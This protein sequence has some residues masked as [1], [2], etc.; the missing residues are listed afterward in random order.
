MTNQTKK[1]NHMM[2]S[3]YFPAELYYRAM[4]YAQKNEISYS[5]L[6][7]LA[8]DAYLAPEKIELLTKD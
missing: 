5:K 4:E 3:V 6:V 8:L 1:Q 2:Q 7:Q